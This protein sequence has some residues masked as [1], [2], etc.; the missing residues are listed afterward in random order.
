MIESNEHLT[1]LGRLKIKLIKS[2]MN[3]KRVF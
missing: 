2:N 1:E 3:S